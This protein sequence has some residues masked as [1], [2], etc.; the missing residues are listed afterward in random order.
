MEDQAFRAIAIRMQDVS[1]ADSM[2]ITAQLIDDIVLTYWASLK[3]K[4][5]SKSFKE[6][7][8]LGHQE[9]F[10]HERRKGH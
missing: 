8:L 3:R 5:P 10:I 1:L 7:I 6:L 2:N 9:L 4:Y